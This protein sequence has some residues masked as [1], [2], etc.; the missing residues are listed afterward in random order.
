MYLHMFNTYFLDV[1]KNHYLDFKGRANRKQ[2]WLFILWVFIISC[3]L[4]FL[5]N[6][7]NIIGTAFTVLYVLFALA[8]LLPNIAIQVRRLHDTGRSGWWWFIGFVPFIGWIVL[9][10]FFLLPSKR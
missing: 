4:S 1:I 10:V 8:V 9:L 7:D 6:M 3:L 5:G 2:F